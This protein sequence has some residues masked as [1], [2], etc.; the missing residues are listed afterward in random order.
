MENVT[1]TFDLNAVTIPNLL[2]V[3]LL[4]ILLSG[5]IWRFRERTAENIS[6]LLMIFFSFTNCLIDPL[7]YIADGHPGALNRFIIV[8]GNTWLFFSQLAAACCWLSF[9]YRHLNGKMSRLQ[10][11]ILFGAATTCVLLLVIN[12][13]V[14]IV[15]EVSGA[16]VYSRKTF[17]FAFA[18]I[19]YLLLLDSLV[20]YLKSRL[21]GG[22]LKFFPFWVYAIPVIVGGIIQSMFYGIS[23]NSVCLAI[24][25]A[26]ILS[27]LQNELIFRD[28]LTSL[29]NRTYL[30]YLLKLYSKN[31]SK[32]VTGIMLDLNAFK[33]INDRFGHAIG[34]EA[35]INSAD[36]FRS[37]VSDLGIVIRYA[38]DEFIVLINSQEDRVIASCM[39][40]IR[41]TLQSFNRNS[42]KSYKLAV[43]M[44]SCKLD[45][46]KFTIDEFINEIDKRMYEDKKIFYA[47]NTEFDR[48]NH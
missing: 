27:S 14:P 16:N 4:C 3:L 5:N 30:D 28:S 20:I 45:F 44:G 39:S 24:S 2:G 22:A 46:D 18:A 31:N 32:A 47:R 33:S 38:G 43:S 7:V 41:R 25:V 13:F 40:E 8:G 37:I 42:G 12:I 34:D 19:N 1:P 11:G 15:F 29:Y 21:R 9:F 26:G 35:L 10:Q 6:L 36:I 23:L 17:F 48:R